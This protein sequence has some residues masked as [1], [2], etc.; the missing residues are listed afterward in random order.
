MASHWTSGFIEPN[1][2]SQ[3]NSVSLFGAW[4]ALNSASLSGILFLS[5]DKSKVI[6][7]RVLQFGSNIS[8]F[9]KQSRGS[10]IKDI[11]KF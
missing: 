1:V 10:H 9:S 11:L 7:D 3:Q 2:F 8:T 5:Y 4:T 6:L